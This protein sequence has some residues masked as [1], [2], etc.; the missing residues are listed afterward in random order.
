MDGAQVG[1]YLG[2]DVPSLTGTIIASQWSTD[3][4]WAAGPAESEGEMVIKEITVN[5][6]PE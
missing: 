4:S 3:N 6:D 2:G 1:H 5:W